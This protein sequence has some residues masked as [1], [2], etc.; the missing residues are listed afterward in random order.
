MTS[1]QEENR[2][3]DVILEKLTAKNLIIPAFVLGTAVIVVIVIFFATLIHATFTKL[4]TNTEYSI[5]ALTRIVDYVP[6]Q[7]L[8]PTANLPEFQIVR[9]IN[10]CPKL[11]EREWIKNGELKFFKDTNVS[12]W[13]SKPSMI[14]ISI[15]PF[16]KN[17][18]K[19][20]ELTSS[21]GRCVTNERITLNI[22]LSKDTSDFIMILI[23]DVT[24]GK[25]LSYDTKTAPLMLEK[26][27]I[28][29][30]DKSFWFE[31]LIRLPS[32]SLNKGDTV[33]IPADISNA[34]TGLLTI[35]H[36]D[37]VFEG[38]FSKKGGEVLIVTPFSSNHGSPVTVSFFERLYSDNALAIA[39]SSSFIVIQ[40]LMYLIT[41]LIRLT[42][43]PKRLGQYDGPEPEPEPELEPIPS[44]NLDIKEEKESQ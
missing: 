24:I 21:K 7:S 38:V 33:V 34:T 16:E 26:G 8:I 11:I 1:E 22:R 3:T 39:L 25:R 32:V 35:N 36:E 6:N 28:E 14:H 31:D 10:Q 12:I 29:I 17:G 15:R 42:Y 37:S 4:D 9:Q 13:S 44:D 2:F 5:Q 30:K 18:K 43:I 40:V 41:T 23:G 27:E 20:A 19:V